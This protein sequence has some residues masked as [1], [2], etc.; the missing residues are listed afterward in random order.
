MAATTIEPPSGAGERPAS[1]GKTKAATTALA[2]VRQRMLWRAVVRSGSQV[3]AS[4]E[5]D[6]VEWHLAAC[7]VPAS[8]G[9]HCT[10]G[11]HL[12][13][14]IGHPDGHCII[15]GACGVCGQPAPASD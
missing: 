11:Q 1:G 13:E 5:R 12:M 7:A 10:E 14:T 8:E 15:D 9:Q 6:R 3:G 4:R 2:P